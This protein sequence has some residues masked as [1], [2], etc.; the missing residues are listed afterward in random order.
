MQWIS[1]NWVLV[2]VFGG[3]LV[4]LVL[5]RGGR[6]GGGG[7]GGGHGGGFLGKL[8]GGH[9]GG[10]GHGRGSRRNTGRGHGH[11]S[12]HTHD[13]D[14]EPRQARPADNEETASSDQ[15]PENSGKQ[16]K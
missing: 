9:S 13:H 10:G 6:H 16:R 8:G 5:R 7:H 2:V 15:G 1:E 3:L 14:D 12:R 4:Y 11:G